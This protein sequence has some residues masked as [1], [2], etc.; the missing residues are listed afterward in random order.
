[1]RTFFTGKP[2]VEGLGYAFP[3][4]NYRSEL[5]NLDLLMRRYEIRRFGFLIR[6]FDLKGG[7]DYLAKTIE[8]GRDFLVLRRGLS[9]ARIGSCFRREGFGK[10]KRF[11]KSKGLS[12]ACRMGIR[13]FEGAEGISVSVCSKKAD[14]GYVLV[15]VF[16]ER[17]NVLYC[18]VLD[19]KGWT[20]LCER[21]EGG[22]LGQ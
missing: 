7:Y 14:F 22:L 18:A 17:K 3:Y 20:R 10:W 19:R 8:C 11:P 1:M 21:V 2:Q 16:S 13:I 15:A 6:D 5:H 9:K 12:L 4:R